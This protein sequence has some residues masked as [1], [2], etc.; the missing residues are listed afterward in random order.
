MSLWSRFFGSK[1]DDEKLVSSIQTAIL[2]DPMIIDHSKVNVD[3]KDGVITLT[4]SVGKQME[5]DHVEGTARD[6]LRYH[7][8]KFERIVNDIRVTTK[9]VA[10]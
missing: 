3:S 10:A 1:Y 7:G 9:A 6:A 4:G 5:K 2:E 8:H